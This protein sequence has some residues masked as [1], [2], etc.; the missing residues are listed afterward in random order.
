ML[1][2]IIAILVVAYLGIFLFMGLISLPGY[3]DISN[4]HVAEYYINKGV[5]DTGSVNLVNSIIWDFRGY[6]TLGEETVLFTAAMGVFLVV[7]K[8]E[9]G[10]YRKKRK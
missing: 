6:D 9:Y 2:K 5:M 4:R 7:R 8:K 3:G 1:R 10:H